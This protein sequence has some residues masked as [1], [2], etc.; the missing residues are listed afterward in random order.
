VDAEGT[1][2]VT[3]TDSSDVFVEK[4]T[5]VDHTN[6]VSR[7]HVRFTGTRMFEAQPESSETNE[8]GTA[9]AVDRP[10]RVYVGG[11]STAFDF[12]TTNGT[13]R[14]SINITSDRDAIIFVLERRMEDT[15]EEER[16]L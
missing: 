9:I 3:G 4:I 5:T 7:Y 11:T 10:D 12:P 16:G 14:S 1:A 15:V 13:H 8:T 2:Y 6:P